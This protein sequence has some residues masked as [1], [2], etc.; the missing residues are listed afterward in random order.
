MNYFSGVNGSLEIDGKKAARVTNWSL[1][2]TMA[3]LGVT[4]LGDTDSVIT[5]GIRSTSGSCTIFY[6]QEIAGDNKENAASDLINEIVKQQAGASEPGQAAE[7]TK[8]R[9]KLQIA[10]GTNAGQYV[11]VDAFISSASIAV[12]VG[13]VV[14]AS[15][16]FDVIGAPVEVSI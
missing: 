7:S 10:D 15:I 11:T 2:T 4:S 8:V 1:S 9:F 3:T 13:E 16:S 14:Q 6:Y 12:A 5:Q